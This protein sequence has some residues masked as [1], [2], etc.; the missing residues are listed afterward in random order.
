[1]DSRVR[2]RSIS[3]YAVKIFLLIPV[4][5]YAVTEILISCFWN[6]IL[7]FVYELC[8][9]ALDRFYSN[10]ENG[11]MIQQVSLKDENSRQN[12]ALVKAQTCKETTFSGVVSASEKVFY[13]SAKS[14]ETFGSFKKTIESKERL[15][16]KEESLNQQNLNTITNTEER[17]PQLIT[18]Q[19]VRQETIW[20]VD[21]D[22]KEEGA[23]LH[24]NSAAKCQSDAGGK[25]EKEEVFSG[26]KI[27]TLDLED[28]GRKERECRPRQQ[29]YL[30]CNLS[31]D[32]KNCES[33]EV[34]GSCRR[35][36]CP[37]SYL[38]AI[39]CESI[40]ENVNG[41]KQANKSV[42][43][44]SGVSE[45]QSYSSALVN[46]HAAT[47]TPAKHCPVSTPLEAGQAQTSNFPS[48]KHLDTV[49]IAPVCVVTTSDCANVTRVVE[50]DTCQT[51]LL[52]TLLEGL[53]RDRYSKEAEAT[54][55]MT[56][57]PHQSHRTFEV[58]NAKMEWPGKFNAP[59]YLEIQ[60]E[61]QKRVKAKNSW[62]KHRVKQVKRSRLCFGSLRSVLQNNRMPLL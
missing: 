18:K 48:S 13:R 16:T 12:V 43:D 54:T 53:V 57:D 14:P 20:K 44:R 51:E 11:R 47:E 21:R 26:E 19:W 1:M 32:S 29:K 33:K 35:K 46:S 39:S 30:E 17:T 6:F 59:H 50:E 58:R 52:N 8:S 9:L 25:H 22:I 42:S 41:L 27:S 31:G 60:N 55:S 40:K 62:S 37:L 45:E 56:G 7:R 3:D 10:F 36:V 61:S 24:K 4:L 2:G 38:N 49:S 5:T 15:Q 34:E 23:L 28:H